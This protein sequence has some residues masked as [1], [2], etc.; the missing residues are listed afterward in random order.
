MWVLIPEKY[1][2]LAG[3]KNMHEE[4]RP[5]APG[6]AVCTPPSVFLTAP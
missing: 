1:F 2:Q 4:S 3:Q 6:L 5:T